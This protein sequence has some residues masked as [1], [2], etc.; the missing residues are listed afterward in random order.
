MLALDDA[1][2]CTF[3]THRV[4]NTYEEAVEY[5]KTVA[6]TRLP[7]VAYATKPFRREYA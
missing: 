5:A 4:F 2:V 1:G 6:H 3:A 7:M